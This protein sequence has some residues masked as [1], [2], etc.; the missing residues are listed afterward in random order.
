MIKSHVNLAA[1]VPCLVTSLLGFSS[2][3]AVIV[4]NVNAK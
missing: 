3:L 1:I 2:H 4:L